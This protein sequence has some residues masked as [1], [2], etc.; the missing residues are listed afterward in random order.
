VV[1]SSELFHKT[2]EVVTK[3]EPFTVRVNAW[4]PGATFVGLSEVIAGPV[5]EVMGR[6]REFEVPAPGVFTAML[7]VPTLATRLA[8]TAAVSWVTF[9]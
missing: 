5:E 1:A 2:V 8:E 4:P 6:E 9:T 3:F 7:A